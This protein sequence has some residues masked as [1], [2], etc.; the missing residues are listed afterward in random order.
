MSREQQ[1][2]FLL[3]V[4]VSDD[5]TINGDDLCDEL[6]KIIDEEKTKLYFSL[7]QF[8]DIVYQLDARYFDEVKDKSWAMIKAL[9]PEKTKLSEDNIELELE[10]ENNKW[11]KENNCELS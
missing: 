4:R 9:K 7:V 1:E 3:K 5:G 10:R 6:H 11:L 8:N 2:Q